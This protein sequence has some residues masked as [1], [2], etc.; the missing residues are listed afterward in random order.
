MNEHLWVKLKLSRDYLIIGSVYRSPSENISNSTTELCDLISKVSNTK[1]TYLVIIGDFNYPRIQ[2]FS[3]PILVSNCHEQLFVDTIHQLALNQ[4]V[5]QPTRF[6]PGTEPHLLDLLL[7]NEASMVESIEYCSGLGKSD[8]VCIKFTLNCFPTSQSNNKSQLFSY[9]FAKG[10]YAR[11]RNLINKFNW[12]HLFDDLNAEESWN[13]LKDHLN[14]IVDDCIPKFSGTKKR[15]HPYITA[16]VIKLKTQ[17]D[18]LWRKYS[19]TQ[20][21]DDYLRFAQKRNLIRRLTR[22]LRV[23][24]EAGIAKV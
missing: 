6:R 15:K 11:A 20:N 7:T 10:D 24:Y 2:W 4:L 16:K 9:N 5:S 12:E 1:P 23:D 22:Q 19:Y 17:K 8:H 14:R 3:N 21:F 18:H 13:I